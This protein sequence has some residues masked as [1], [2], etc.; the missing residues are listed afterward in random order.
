MKLLFKNSKKFIN[1]SF[2]IHKK[3]YKYLMSF[4]K[5]NILLFA[6]LFFI[7]CSSLETINKG[8]PQ[9]MDCFFTDKYGN[10]ISEYPRRSNYIYLV[11]LTENSIGEKVTLEMNSKPAKTELIYKGVYL[12]EKIY[13]TIHR[14][15][16]KL[17][18][19]IYNP[20]NI[21]HRHLKKKA[22]K[23]K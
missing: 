7:A 23:S 3:S 5:T 18:L 20:K 16:E 15:K 22:M 8:E 13:F 19:D 21:H 14:D 6:P 9:L 11:V 10:K 12:S 4:K 2:G 1:T 17:K